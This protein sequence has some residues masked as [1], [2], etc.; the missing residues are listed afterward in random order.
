MDRVL[1]KTNPK[2]FDLAVKP[3]QEGLAS[4]ILWLDH[5]F[6]LCEALTNVKDGKRFTSANHY[7]GN[8]QYE[9][10]M[11]CK[12]LG[13]FAFFYLRDP[14]SVYQTNRNRVFS[15]ITLIIWFDIRKVSLSTDER[16]KEAIKAQILGA[17][18]SL[19]NPYFTVTKIYE[20]P[21]TVFK[22]FSYE[23]TNNQFLM[24][25][26]A[27]F[28]IDGEISAEI[29]CFVSVGDFNTDYNEDYNIQTEW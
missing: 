22:D 12:E 26:Y 9:Q 13:N 4:R 20:R 3:I 29:P 24:A 1:T 15:P 6:G 11:P 21:E 19:H 23:H 18:N 5:I 14:Q 2:M 7:K 27:G 10:V 17:I 28:R 16:Q 25:P 8:G